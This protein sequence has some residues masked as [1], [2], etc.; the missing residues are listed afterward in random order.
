MHKLSC[1]LGEDKRKEKLKVQSSIKDMEKKRNEM[2]KKLY[3]SQDEMDV[4][5]E[6]LIARVEAQLRQRTKLES[7]FIVRWRMV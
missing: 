4:R 2:R 3:D 5:K 7:L 6:D 1:G